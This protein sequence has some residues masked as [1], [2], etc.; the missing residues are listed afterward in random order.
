MLLAQD[1]SQN[2]Q[3]TSQQDA[4]ASAPAKPGQTTKEKVTVD[5]VERSYLIHL[6][7]GYDSSRHYPVVLLLHA[8]NQDADDMSRLTHFDQL[9]DQDSVIAV[10]P[11][12]LHGRWNVGVHVPERQTMGPMG[13]RRRRGYGYPGGGYPGGGGGYPP[14][15][16]YPGGGQRQPQDDSQRE[17]RPVPADDIA[18]FNELLDQLPLKYSVDVSRIYVTGLADGGFMT[19]KAGCSMGDRV[20]AI[21]PVAAA[22]PK[23]FVC[24]PAR[25]VSVMMIDGTSDPIVP[26]DGGT[27]KLDRIPTI[28][29][30]K[31]AEQWAK[32]DHCSDKPAHSK[33]SAKEKGGME[34]K[35]DT[36]EGCQENSSVVLYSVKGGGDTWPGG[37]QYSVEKEIGKT[38]HDLDANQ[39]IWSF[40]V[41]KKLASSNAERK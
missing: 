19:I 23:N 15:G 39:A 25:P 34:T 32:L 40:F 17:K 24:I 38:S 20:A 2:T 18:F 9:A 5:N 10:Y 29:V 4:T 21:A 11:F 1:S 14:G 12:A 28:S 6:P 22:M 41:T 36:Y 27:D 35:V 31:S 33:I 8:A 16:G 13:P 3:K 37:E 26:Y 30:D 7:T